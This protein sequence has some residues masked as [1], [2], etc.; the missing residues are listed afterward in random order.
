MKRASIHYFR[1]LAGTPK[2]KSF[3]MANKITLRSKQ[4]LV[5]HI[6]PETHSLKSIFG[7]RHCGAVG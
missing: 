2:S 3:I 5:L 4:E 6:I 1:V 7:G